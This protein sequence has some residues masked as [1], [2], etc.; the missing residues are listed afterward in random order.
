MTIVTPSAAAF[1]PRMVAEC[2]D[3]VMN[4]L[5]FVRTHLAMD[6]A[7]VLEFVGDEIVF[8]AVSAPGFEGN[9][10]VGG[11]RP[12]KSGYF[13]HIVAGRLPELIPDTA[14]EPLAQTIPVTHKLPIRSYVSVPIRRTDGTVY[15]MFAALAKPRALR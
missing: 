1:V 7:Y 10:A 8:C 11:T 6:I 12:P 9:F 15:G 3:L 4:S 14:Y 13:H 2:D 5:A